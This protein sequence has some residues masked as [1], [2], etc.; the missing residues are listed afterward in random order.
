M[1]DT[2]KCLWLGKRTL[3]WVA[4]GSMVGLG[5]T[6][7][8]TSTMVKSSK[9]CLIFFLFFL[10]FKEKKREKGKWD[11]VSILLGFVYRYPKSGCLCPNST[12]SLFII[13]SKRPYS[14][15]WRCQFMCIIIQAFEAWFTLS[16]FNA[17]LIWIWAE[18]KHVSSSCASS[19][20]QVVRPSI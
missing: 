17:P 18:A 3:R 19:W 16:F 20:M 8:Y 14:R 5:W 13:S 2:I 7:T 12:F 1:N 9:P 10:F 6:S 15:R 4:L 11:N